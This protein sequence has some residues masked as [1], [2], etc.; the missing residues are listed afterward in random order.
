M[1]TAHSQQPGQP[2]RFLAH[3]LHLLRR[4]P[5]NALS[6]AELAQQR[7]QQ[8]IQAQA[9]AVTWRWMA[10]R[11]TWKEAQL[12]QQLQQLQQLQQAQVDQQKQPPQTSDWL[13]AQAP[14]PT[15]WRNAGTAEHPTAAEAIRLADR[16]GVVAAEI[17]RRRAP[18]ASGDH[19]Y[20]AVVHG[21]QGVQ[22]VAG[23]SDTANTANY[24]P[25]SKWMVRIRR[26]YPDQISCAC[27]GTLPQGSVCGHIG[28]VLRLRR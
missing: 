25:G 4:K 8:R 12:A 23:I 15:E 22:G 13:S 27:G 21:V 3:L 5:A 19:L 24:A 10:G 28:A 1:R 18:A 9:Q 7:T 16:Y 26:H 6:A 2:H 14:F 17:D 20:I 11:A